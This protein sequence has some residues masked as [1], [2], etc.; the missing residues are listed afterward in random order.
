MSVS[1]PKPL[2]EISRFYKVSK[3][4]LDDISTVAAAFSLWFEGETISNA[5][6]AYGGVAATP[7]RTQEAENALLGRPWNEDTWSS[8]RPLLNGAFSPMDD[9]RG[10]ARYRA[11]MVTQLFDKFFAQT[12]SIGGADA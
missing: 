4:V 3:R 1:I 8:V 5:R 7:V 9:H 6:L 11:E 2:P 12:R 10:S